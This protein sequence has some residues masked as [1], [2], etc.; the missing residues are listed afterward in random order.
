MSGSSTSE[1]NIQGVSDILV[2]KKSKK[3]LN[4]K[5]TLDINEN[6]SKQ[7]RNQMKGLSMAKGGPKF[8]QQYKIK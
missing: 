5:S 2:Y 4:K 6:V 3:V 8:K 7:L 1:W